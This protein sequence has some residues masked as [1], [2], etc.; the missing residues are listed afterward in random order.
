MFHGAR[1]KYLN[2][3]NHATAANKKYA[4]FSAVIAWRPSP[5]PIS[6]CRLFYF[7]SWAQPFF[8]FS[9]F[10]REMVSLQHVVY[11]VCSA[12]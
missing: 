3:Q 5:F 11:T 1:L 6:T 7:F 12:N 9:K 10:L 4:R 2:G 8:F